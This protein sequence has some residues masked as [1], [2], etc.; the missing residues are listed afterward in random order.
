MTGP[1]M[2]ADLVSAANVAIAWVGP[3]KAV[4]STNRYVPCGPGATLGARADGL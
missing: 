2:S 1:G 4:S 3:V